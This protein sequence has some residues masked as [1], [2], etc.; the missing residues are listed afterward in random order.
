[1]QL[2]SNPYANKYANK[3]TLKTTCSSRIYTTVYYND[4]YLLSF[5]ITKWQMFEISYKCSW[6]ILSRILYILN[7]DLEQIIWH[8]ISLHQSKKLMVS[9]ISISQI[10][11][12]AEQ[13]FGSLKH[14]TLAISKMFPKFLKHFCNFFSQISLFLTPACTVPAIEPARM[15]KYS[16]IEFFCSFFW[17]NILI[18]FFDI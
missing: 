12:N 3:E 2:D 17:S 1:M 7:F 5:R 18:W 8:L 10:L 11:A 15:S 16:Q 9:R 13:L 4:R 14:V 6:F